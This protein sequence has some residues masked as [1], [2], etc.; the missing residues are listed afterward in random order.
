MTVTYGQGFGVAVPQ[1]MRQ[2][3]ET[4]QQELSKLP[5]YEPETKHYFHGGM[6]CREVF[7]HAGVLVV[8]AV[9]KK[10]HFYLIVSGTVQ[11]TDGEGNAQEVTGPHLFQSKPGTK[12]A[13]YAVTDTLCMTF[14][15]TESKTVEEAEAE[16]VEVEPDSMYSLGNQVKHKEIEV[17]P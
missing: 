7:R 3:V 17:Q 5:Q 12:R 9:H 16:L 11:I 8:G 13:V 6:Y 2:K 15:A 1:M 4:L 10:E 14:H